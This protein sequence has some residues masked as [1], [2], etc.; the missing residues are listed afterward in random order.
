MSNLAGGGAGAS[1]QSG[2]RPRRSRPPASRANQPQVSKLGASGHTP[3]RG[4][5][6]YVGRMPRIPQKLAGTRTEPPV[7]LPTAKSTTPPA[8]A[9][10][11]PLDEPPV[12]RPGALTFTGAP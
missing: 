1:S 7:S 8:T 12:M 2:V 4:M 3:S 9:E 11:D 10:A 5:R 6:P